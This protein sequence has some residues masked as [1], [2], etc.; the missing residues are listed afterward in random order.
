MIVGG[1]KHVLFEMKFK[2]ST[3]LT[4]IKI[5]IGTGN[6]VNSWAEH[7]IKFIL[8]SS[9]K[10]FNGFVGFEDGLNIIFS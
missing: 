8:S 9:K 7:W 3:H 4:Y 6:L 1:V 10:L 5:Y 2:L